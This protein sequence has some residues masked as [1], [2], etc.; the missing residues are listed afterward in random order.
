[1]LPNDSWSSAPQPSDF[2]PPHNADRFDPL[3]AQD[4]GPIAVSDITQGLRA[5]MWTATCDGSAVALEGYGELFSDTGITQISLT[6]DQAGKPFVAYAAGGMVKIWW[7]DPTA[8][9]TVT[10]EISMGDQPF[11]HLDERRPELVGISDVIIL[12]R[13]AGALRYRKQRDRFL[14]EMSTPIA[15]ASQLAI[16]A[17]GMSTGGRLQVK[18]LATGFSSSP[19]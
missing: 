7:F 10:T 19:D 4:A 9:D 12:Y 14:V 1:M 3:T 17:F 18:Y 2:L 11:A 15:N 5:R 16:R 6:F 8:G 13:A